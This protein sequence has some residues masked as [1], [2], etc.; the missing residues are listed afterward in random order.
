MFVLNRAIAV[1]DTYDIGS[2]LF[3]AYMKLDN[4]MAAILQLWRECRQLME[5]ISQVQICIHCAKGMQLV[6]T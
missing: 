6:T 1:G 5:Q 2:D 4:E 3:D